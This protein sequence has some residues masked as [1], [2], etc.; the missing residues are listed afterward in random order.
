MIISGLSGNE[1]YC[2]DKKGYAPGRIV[3]GNCVFSLGTVRGLTSG[4]Q[5]D[6]PAAKSTRSP[7]SSPTAATPPS[8]G[9]GAE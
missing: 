7:S 9:L 3:V 5:D 6:S 4:H 1:I 8:S 2:L